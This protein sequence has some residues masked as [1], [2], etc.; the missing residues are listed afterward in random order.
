MITEAKQFEEKAGITYPFLFSTTQQFLKEHP[1]MVQKVLNAY[2]KGNKY[3]REH[4]DEAVK[5]FA[6]AA[7]KRGAKLTEDIVRVML[8]DTDRFGGS[9]FSDGD[10]KDLPAT[11]AFMM[12]IGKL[13]SPPAA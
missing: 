6:E 9:A 5:I 11:R 4:K 8:F 3:I 1:D 7:N 12:K 10:M 13:K 2:A